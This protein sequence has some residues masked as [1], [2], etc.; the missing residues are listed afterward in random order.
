M[1][2]ETMGAWRS[3]EAVPVLVIGAGQAGLAAAYW[4]KQEG[5]ASIVVEAA[6]RIGDSWRKRYSSLTLFTPRRFSALPDLELGGRPRGLCVARRIRRLPGTLRAG[7]WVASIDGHDRRTTQSARRRI[8]S[9]YDDGRPDPGTQRHH[10][11]GRLSAGRR[12][13]ARGEHCRRR[14]AAHR[15]KLRSAFQGGPWDGAGRWRW[16]KWPRHCRRT[17]PF[18]P[19][20]TVYWKAARPLSRAYSWPERLV[21]AFVGGADEGWTGLLRWATHAQRRR[22][23]RPRSQLCQSAATWREHCS[24]ARRGSWSAGS[25]CGRTNGDHRCSCVGCWLSRRDGWAD[26]SRC[27]GRP[28]PLRRR[29]GRFPQSPVSILSAALGSAIARRDS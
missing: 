22:F 3:S 2:A 13:G 26:R 18:S 25:I 17:R 6:E 23:P 5:L 20:H 4:L 15:G 9:H 8:W 12:P 29:G 10:R 19:R 27:F 1:S 7:P 16:C 14:S 28:R 21:V 24:A 11:H